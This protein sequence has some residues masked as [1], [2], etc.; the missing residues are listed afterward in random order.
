MLHENLLNTYYYVCTK[1]FGAISTKGKTEVEDGWQVLTSKINLIRLT[2][3]RLK[4]TDPIMKT[5]CKLDQIKSITNDKWVW[6]FGIYHYVRNFLNKKN[7]IIC[8]ILNIHWWRN[9]LSSM[10]KHIMY[11]Y[12]ETWKELD[13]VN[14]ITRKSNTCTLWWISTRYYLLLKQ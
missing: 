6:F 2:L 5:W 11:G 8:V 9:L 4:E 14:V 7:G 1:R 12:W 3:Y 10:V 13:I